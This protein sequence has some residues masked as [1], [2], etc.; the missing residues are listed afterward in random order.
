MV[1]IS[2]RKDYEIGVRQV[3]AEHRKLF[4][5]VNAY[6]DQHLQG[7]NRKEIERVLNALVTY[8]QTH[9]QNEEALM[10][11]YAYPK[12]EEHRKQHEALFS[13]IFS[14]TEE[15]LSNP[16]KADAETL[17]FLKKWLS[18]H[19]VHDDVDIGDFL[20]LKARHDN[21]HPVEELTEI[22]QEAALNDTPQ[23]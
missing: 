21:R 18:D 20:R 19:I 16:A 11:K 2:W 13:S 1:F 23:A 4:D 12:L 7:Y 3:D 10:E 15:L 9:F 22:P 5:L 6:Y 14:I 8:A 17:Q